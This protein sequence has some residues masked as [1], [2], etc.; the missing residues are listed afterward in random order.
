MYGYHSFLGAGQ[1]T[2]PYGVSG[3]I[4]QNLTAGGASPSPTRRWGN[5]PWRRIGGRH[6]GPSVPVYG[7]SFVRRAP[8]PH[9]LPRLVG[10]RRGGEM[11]QAEILHRIRAQWPGRNHTRNRI[12][13]AGNFAEGCRGIPRRWGSGG[14]ATMGGDA[15]RSLPPAAF[16]LLCRRGQRRSPRRAKPCKIRRAESSRPTDVMVH[17]G[18]AGLRPAPTTSPANHSKTG[19]QEGKPRLSERKNGG[20]SGPPFAAPLIPRR[21]Y[22]NKQAVRRASRSPL[23]WGRRL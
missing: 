23:R 5:I 12:L 11:E 21:S 14:G 16:C 13:R 17:E 10:T 4:Q 22:S 7:N 20:P 6:M 19:Q 8:D 18:R 3:E 1:E 9:P 2:R 15:H